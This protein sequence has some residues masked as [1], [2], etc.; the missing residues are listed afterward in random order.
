MLSFAST[1]THTLRNAV[2][3]AHARTPIHAQI[4]WFLFTIFLQSSKK[5]KYLST[6]THLQ[7]YVHPYTHCL[8]IIHSHAFI[9]SSSLT[10]THSLILFLH[11]SSV[12]H[13]PFPFCLHSHTFTSVFLLT[14]THSLPHIH[15]RTFTQTH[16][17]THIHSHTFTQTHSLT[18]IHSHTFTHKHSLSLTHSVFYNLVNRSMLVGLIHASKT[19]NEFFLPTH[20]RP[21]PFPGKSFELN[22]L[23]IVGCCR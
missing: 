6:H 18:R 10:E 9:Q 11:A 1:H 15:S 14:Q 12:T 16:S 23:G 13:I 17:L 21:K 22:I 2:T 8:T 7:P 19:F 5:Q 20:K 3:K 4:Y